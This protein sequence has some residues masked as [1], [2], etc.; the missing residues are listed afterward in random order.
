MNER[1]CPFGD[2]FCLCRDGFRIHYSEFIE[3]EP[4]V[5]LPLWMAW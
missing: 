1:H 2:P 5:A 4:A 3:E